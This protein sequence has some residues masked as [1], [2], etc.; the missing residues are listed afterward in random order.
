VYLGAI[1]SSL[2]PGPSCWPVE[3][4]SKFTRRHFAQRTFSFPSQL[5]HG[6]LPH[7]CTPYQQISVLWCLNGMAGCDD[8]F[9]SHIIKSFS[10]GVGNRL[11]VKPL[12][13][14]PCHAHSRP[15]RDIF[16]IHEQRIEWFSSGGL[17]SRLMNN[18]SGAQRAVDRFVRTIW[19]WRRPAEMAKAKESHVYSLGP[20]SPST[21]TVVTPVIYCF[22]DILTLL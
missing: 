2:C 19:L 15:S 5:F 22:Q 9:L 3:L 20:V 8:I 12:C 13:N 1:N 6:I 10:E 7:G 18:T 21:G 17:W 4:W 14:L 11:L 16:W